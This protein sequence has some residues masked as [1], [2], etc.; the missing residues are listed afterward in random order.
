MVDPIDAGLVE[1]GADL[2]VD[3]PGRGKVGP[4][5]L[6]DHQPRGLGGEAR[7]REATR[8]RPEEF[9]RGGEIDHAHAILGAR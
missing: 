6:F 9:G 3:P 5:R 2:V 7:A 8:D 4:H 1:I